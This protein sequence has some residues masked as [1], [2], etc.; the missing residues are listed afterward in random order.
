MQLAKNAASQKSPNFKNLLVR[1]TFGPNMQ[2]LYCTFLFILMI[3]SSFV[4]RSKLGFG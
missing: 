1:P 2:C 3:A 4:W